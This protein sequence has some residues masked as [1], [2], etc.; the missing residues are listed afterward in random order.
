MW[1]TNCLSE[2][3]TEKYHLHHVKEELED[4]LVYT[5]DLLDKLGVDV[6]WIVNMKME[7]NERK[8]HIE[9]SKGESSEV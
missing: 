6:D 4:V 2:M 7:Q 9:K 3:H 5:R 1:S 8:Y